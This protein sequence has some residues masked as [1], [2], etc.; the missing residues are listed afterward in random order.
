MSLPPSA[1]GADW[2]PGYAVTM[3]RGTIT[4]GLAVPTEQS[5][6]HPN[7]SRE[8]SPNVS[9]ACLGALNAES[10]NVSILLR[11]ALPNPYP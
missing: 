8:E 4:I 3:G 9:L 10:T 2:R 1:G 5:L 7:A 6:K 11:N